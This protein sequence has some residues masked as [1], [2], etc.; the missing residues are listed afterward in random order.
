MGLK[1]S[2]LLSLK[3]IAYHDDAALAELPKNV[4]H[5]LMEAVKAT[6]P[7]RL[8]ALGAVRRYEAKP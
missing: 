5:D 8:P 7:R 3:A 1:F 4:R 6:N 2:A